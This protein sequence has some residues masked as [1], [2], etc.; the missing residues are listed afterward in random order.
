M[1]Y[2]CIKSEW[3]SVSKNVY[4]TFI[5]FFTSIESIWVKIIHYC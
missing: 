5:Y 3:D 4:V 2:N 1:F